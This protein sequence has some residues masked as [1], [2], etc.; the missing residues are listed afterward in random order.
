MRPLLDPPYP[1]P[2]GVPPKGELAASLALG[3]ASAARQCAPQN[4]HFTIWPL[5]QKAIAHIHQPPR[6][7]VDH[8]PLWWHRNPSF[9]LVVVD[10]FAPVCLAVGSPNNSR[11]FWRISA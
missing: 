2:L 1:D 6:V 9:N 10:H 11:N 7:L 8:V 5:D 4:L 3:I